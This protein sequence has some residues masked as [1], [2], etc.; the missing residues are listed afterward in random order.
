MSKP[1]CGRWIRCRLIDDIRTVPELIDRIMTEADEI[2][3]E[4]LADLLEPAGA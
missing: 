3:R 2:I 1:A 4:A